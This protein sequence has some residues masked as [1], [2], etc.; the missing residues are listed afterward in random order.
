MSEEVGAGVGV[1][2]SGVEGQGLGMKSSP[3]LI[4][5]VGAVFER[6]VLP[7]RVSAVP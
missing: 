3:G 5:E 6:A 7:V 4:P 1:P 2:S